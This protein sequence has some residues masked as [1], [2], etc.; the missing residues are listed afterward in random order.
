VASTHL[1]SPD[2]AARFTT[3]IDSWPDAIEQGD[4]RKG[5]KYW[6]YFARKRE[7]FDGAFAFGVSGIPGESA[8][9]Y[10]RVTFGAGGAVTDVAVVD[11]DTAIKTSRIAMEATL[12][13]WTA[14][15]EGYDIGKAMT[16][17]MLP[18]TKGG[19]LDLL[20][21]VYFLHELLVIFTRV[22]TSAQ[23]AA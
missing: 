20:R 17:H 15:V 6:Q 18:L 13:N 21:C 4:E 14:I 7:G 11:R 8:A 1:F 19:S 5:D 12:D 16:Y 2:A 23:V 10:I 9:P 3:L 22:E